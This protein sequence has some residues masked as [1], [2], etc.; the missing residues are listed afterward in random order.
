VHI[1]RTAA[2]QSAIFA[3]DRGMPLFVAN[4]TREHVEEWLS[5]ILRRRSPA[6]ADTRYRGLKAFF[7]WCVE[8][9]EIKASPM[10]RVRKPDT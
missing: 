6:T 8:E 7:D 10:A 9:G 3:H 1:G 2:A 5:E 4:V